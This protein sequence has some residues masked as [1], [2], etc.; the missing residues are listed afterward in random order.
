MKINTILIVDDSKT[1]Q[2]IIKRCFDIAGYADVE[3]FF[4]GDG[5]EA[6]QVLEET[7]VDL[8]VTDLNMPNCDGMTLIEKITANSNTNGLKI[9]VVSSIAGNA[10]NEK[11]EA[12]LGSINKPLSPKKIIEVL[13]VNSCLS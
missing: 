5:I 3:Y 8:L 1:S 12:V 13:G 7:T 2:M 6:L 4:A 9:I 11:S 10:Y